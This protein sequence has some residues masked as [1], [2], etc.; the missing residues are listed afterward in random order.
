MQWHTSGDLAISVQY[1]SHMD[2]G[3]TWFGQDYISVIRSRYP[4]RVFDHGLEWC[5][6]PGFI[7][8]N[9]LSHALCRKITLH[10][11]Y[12]P[13]IDRAN[14]TIHINGITD[15][16]DAYCGAD[17]TSVPNHYQFDLVVAN[18]P[19]YLEC[20]GDS[21]YQR[22]A[23]D[24]DWQAHRRFYEHIGGYLAQDGVALI[25]ENQ[26]GSLQGGQEFRHMIEYNGLEIQDVFPSTQFWNQ[27]GP[28]CQ[29]YYLEIRAKK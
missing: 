25:Q 14:E 19:H 15:R 20:P 2:G 4:D 5:A 11:C 8:F 22:L 27:P 29:I 12:A 18:P 7:G 24:P 6:G 9:L 3:G 26:A 23:V 17:I 16:A 13:A 21:N 10:D 28:W 1:D